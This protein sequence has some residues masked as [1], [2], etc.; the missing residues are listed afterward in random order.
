MKRLKVILAIVLG[1]ILIGYITFYLTGPTNGDPLKAKL[2]TTDIDNFWLAYDASGPDFKPS[3]FQELYLDKGSKGLKGFISNRIQSSEYLSKV[4]NTH[5]NYYNS[6]RESTNK[7][8]LMTEQIREDM[9][10]FKKVY[11]DAVFPPIYFVIGALSSG[12]TSF[13]NGLI[14]GAEMYGLTPETPMEELND[15]LKSVLKG[16]DELP[17]IVIHELVHFQQ[18]NSLMSLFDEQTLLSASIHEGAA[19]LIAELVS[20]KH[21]NGHVHEFANPR[22]EELWN[23]FRTLMLG[24]DYTG[25]LYS[26]QEGRPNDLGYWIGYKI[27]KSYYDNANDKNKAISDII[28]VR[29]F[30]KFLNESKY[31]DKFKD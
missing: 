7:I 30:E 5:L 1:L 18:N 4:I 21:I 29:D 23:E 15:W 27:T 25:W 8:P 11:P 19:D 14:I 13:R 2:V 16:V 28:H 31:A 6:I 9:T 22:E 12:G 10:K 24:N 26:S 17:H 3:V 20:G